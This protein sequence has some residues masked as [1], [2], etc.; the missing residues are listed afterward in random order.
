MGYKLKRITIRPNGVEKQI[1]P[2]VEP[3]YLC[4][5]SEEAN[6]TI[7]LHKRGSPTAV[8]LETS[9]DWTTWSD[10]TFDAYITLANVWDKVYFRNKST[11]DTWFSTGSSNYYQFIMSWAIGASWDITTLLNKKGTK[12]LHGN[13]CFR[14]LFSNSNLTTAPSLPATTL[15]DYCY[16]GMFNACISLSTIPALPATTLTTGCYYG[17]FNKCYQLGLSSSQ[18]WEYQTPYRIPTTWTWTAGAAS[19]DNMFYNIGGNIS[20][21]P[22]INT[23]YYTKNTVV[24]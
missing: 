7:R 22:S 12:T 1:R 10:Y 13:D 21:T 18:T 11:T 20:D 17:M 3:D 2:K 14:E 15:T 6:V 16:S 4:F 24:S 19:L 8:S 9:T 5:T 23:T